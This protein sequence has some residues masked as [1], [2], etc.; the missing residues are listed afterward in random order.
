MAAVDE[1]VEV[2]AVGNETNVE[3]FGAHPSVHVD[4]FTDDDEGDL[5]AWAEMLSR[6]RAD[7][8]MIED[9]RRVIEETQ[10]IGDLG[11][12]PRRRVRPP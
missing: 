12:D 7:P 5:F 9:A 2:D 3:P 4:R 10:K 6:P 8:A 1:S 11:H